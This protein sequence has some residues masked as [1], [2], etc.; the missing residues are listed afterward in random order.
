MLHVPN[1]QVPPQAN[2]LT[3]D[4]LCVSFGRDLP[5][6]TAVR[7]VSFSLQAGRCLAIVGG[8][9]SGKSVT[10]RAIV[11]LAGRRAHV[12]ARQLTFAGTDLTA[13]DDRSWRRVRGKEIGFVLQDALVALDPL[14]PV[15]KE[16]GEALRLHRAVASSEELE[17]R[18]VAL[19]ELVRVPEAAVKARQLPHQLSGGQRQR[20]L[21][22][23]ALALDPRIL[24]AD[25]P[26]TALDVTVQAQVLGLLEE[27]KLR[28]KALLLISHDLAVV[29]RIADE[30]L[31]M[32]EGKVVERGSADQVFQDPQHTY[33]RQLLDAVPS[34]RLRGSRPSRLP[35]ARAWKPPLRSQEQS[36]STFPSVVLSAANLVKRFKG[37]DGVLR[38]A[39][40]G[41]SFE[42]RSGETLGV[43]GESGSGKSTMARLALALDPPDEGAVLF[44]GRAW[45]TLTER[46]RRARR[47]AISVIYQDPLSSFD[48]RWSVGHIISDSLASDVESRDERYERVVELLDLVGLSPAL[49]DRR[50][51]ELSGGQRQ[52]VA[53]ARAIAPRPAVIVCDE[54]LSALDVLI[55]AQVLDLLTDL[56]AHLNMSYIFIS[57]DLGV[58]RQLSDRVMVMRQGRVVE[59]GTRDEIFLNPR[60]DYTQRLLAAVPSL[61]RGGVANRSFS[62][63]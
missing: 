6:G 45:T 42:L 13:L 33:T 37:P 62:R 27:T 43:V 22:A 34:A 59:T 39:V 49:L 18:V 9:G 11:G 28:G 2:L 12:H 36:P 44:Q 20:A 41:I 47:R 40:D 29:S 25:E 51:L 50:P 5:E 4:S 24:I 58:I 31:V 14:R 35:A 1:R 57:H 32:H 30:V 55:Q 15:G 23:A 17:R 61:A 21:I 54:P 3:V 19:L 48:P 63:V 53:I 26:T 8:S 56:K 38:T 46:D 60:T 52:R 7:G 16:I 10:S